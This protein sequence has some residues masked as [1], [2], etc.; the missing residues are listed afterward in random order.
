MCPQF[1]H[2][3]ELQNFKYE[4]TPIVSGYIMLSLVQKQNK[5]KQMKHLSPESQFFIYSNIL[6]I[7]KSKLKC[8]EATRLMSHCTT[9]FLI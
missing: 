2:Y 4:I 7:F 6:I 3:E 5:T 8:V 9:V 1:T